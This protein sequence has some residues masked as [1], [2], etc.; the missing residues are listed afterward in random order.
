MIVEE[1]FGRAL[2]LEP[3]LATVVLGGGAAAPLRG[4]EALLQGAGAG[5]RRGQAARSRF[6][7]RSGRRATT[8]PTSATTA[9]TD[10]KGG[11]VLD[12]EKSVVLHGD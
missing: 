4:S 2:A 11:Y 1:A 12:G 7:H 8:S 5:H 3:Y 9:R 10:G 6:A